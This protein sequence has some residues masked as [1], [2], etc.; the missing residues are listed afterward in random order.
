M[1]DLRSGTELT[2]RP[3]RCE[4]LDVAA[5]HHPVFVERSWPDDQVALYPYMAEQAGPAVVAVIRRLIAPGALPALVHCASGKDR[6]GLVI[7]VIQTLLDASE[8]QVTEDFLRSNAA[9]D[10][11]GPPADTVS[12]HGTRPVTATH[13]LHAMI[14]IRSSHGSPSAYLEAHGATDAE[15]A[16]LRACL[17]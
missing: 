6:T 16:A 9:L 1:I 13:L 8:A 15:L 10:L 3:D 5:C 11:T 17:T 2:E 4:G 12:G 14:W 7:A